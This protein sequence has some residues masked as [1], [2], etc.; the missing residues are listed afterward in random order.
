MLPVR[1]YTCNTVLENSKG[2]SA[3]ERMCCRRM[4]LAHADLSADFGAHANVDRVLDS[5]NTVLFRLAKDPRTVSC[6]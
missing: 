2:W 5:N 1:C 6:N 3:Y 4:L